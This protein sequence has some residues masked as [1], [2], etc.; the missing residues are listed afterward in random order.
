MKDV[1][2]KKLIIGLI[3]I[4]SAQAFAN[5][6]LTCGVYLIDVKSN[7]AIANKIMT[8]NTS[9]VTIS[10]DDGYGFYVESTK[11][12]LLRKPVVTSRIDFS[13]TLDT[14]TNTG[15][16]KFYRRSEPN[17]YGILT[18]TEELGEEIVAF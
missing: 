7:E 12:R 1:F 11:R 6:N 13:N 10:T 9:G 18:K 14:G 5:D 4:F 8:Q 2:M 15:T 16:F 17:R 3:V